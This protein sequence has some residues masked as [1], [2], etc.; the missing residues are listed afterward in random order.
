MR[1]KTENRRQNRLRLREEERKDKKG[2]ERERRKL[3]VAK[4]CG[5]EKRDENARIERRKARSE[6][7]NNKKN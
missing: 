3:A 5:D 4:Y 6:N 1:E 7:M 2:E